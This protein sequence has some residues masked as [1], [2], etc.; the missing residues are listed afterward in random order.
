[1]GHLGIGIA[2]LCALATNV[3][4]LCKHRGAVRAPAVQFRRPLHSAVE[5]FRS[6]WWL[7]GFGI[8]AGAWVLHVGALTLAPLS[9]VETVISGGLVLLAYPAE[10]WFGLKIGRRE[11]IGL[12]LSATGLVLLAVSSAGVAGHAHSSYSTAAMVSFDTPKTAFS[13]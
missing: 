5:L 10:R 8:A 3:A 9:V 2:L 11:R 6:R 1:M 12:I 7:I 4:F 13:G